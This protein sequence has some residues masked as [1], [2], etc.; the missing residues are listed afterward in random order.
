MKILKTL[1]LALFLLGITSNAKAD[2]STQRFP[3]SDGICWTAADGAPVGNLSSICWWG[4]N[5]NVWSDVLGSRVSDC[6]GNPIQGD[7]EIIDT[8]GQYCTKVHGLQATDPPTTNYNPIGFKFDWEYIW[9]AGWYGIAPNVWWQ[10]VHIGSYRLGP[11]TH[12][13]FCQNRLN[14]QSFNEPCRGEVQ[15]YVVSG[16]TATSG[17]VN[18]LTLGFTIGTNAPLPAN[19]PSSPAHVIQ[20]PTSHSATGLRVVI[21][22][23]GLPRNGGYATIGN[24]IIGPGGVPCYGSDPTMGNKAIFEYPVQGPAVTLPDGTTGSTPLCP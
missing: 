7:A 12:V 10:N 18:L 8:T 4:G 19:C 16:I 3:D 1:I 2:I 15:Q 5:F 21:G 13:T 20:C 17:V 22:G 11:N 6:N 23:D 9:S 14:N 24:P